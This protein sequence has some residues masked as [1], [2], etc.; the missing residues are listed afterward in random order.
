MFTFDTM[1]RLQI[2][3]LSR[4]I[5]N[6]IIQECLVRSNQGLTDAKVKHS[7]YIDKNTIE[8][9]RSWS[10]E[11][12]AQDWIDWLSSIINISSYTISSSDE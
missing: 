12:A 4:P 7:R 6:Q 5:Q 10:S 1:V 9:T 11:S 8:I 2:T 3:D